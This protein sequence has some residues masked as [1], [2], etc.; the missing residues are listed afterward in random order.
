MCECERVCMACVVLPVGV[1][2]M[3]GNLESAAMRRDSNIVENMT[4][5]AQ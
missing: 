4:N 1:C 5:D 2:A 3:L